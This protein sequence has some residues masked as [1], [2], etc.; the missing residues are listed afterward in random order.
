MKDW[1]EMIQKVGPLRIGIMA[2]CGVLLLFLT[3]GGS[4]LGEETQPQVSDSVSEESVTD[5][6]EKLEMELEELLSY[7]EG[8]GTVRVMLTMKSTEENLAFSSQEEEIG[9]VEGVVVVCSG[10]KDSYVQ[11]EIIEAI[12]ALFQLDSHKIKIMKSKEAKE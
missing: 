2:L 4:F 9:T 6:K 3:W 7:V 10:A 8:I 12:S 1:K 11:R 5:R